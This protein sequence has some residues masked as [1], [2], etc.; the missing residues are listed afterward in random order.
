MIASASTGSVITS[1]TRGT[2]IAPMKT[3]AST[4]S[5]FRYLCINI[6]VSLHMIIQQK[7]G[8]A[9]L[10]WFHTWFQHSSSRWSALL[11]TDGVAV[12]RIRPRSR[13]LVTPGGVLRR[14]GL[15]MDG[16]RMD[17]ID[18]WSTA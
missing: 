6:K 2:V 14:S 8:E 3:S 15:R 13:W 10:T 9:C 5:S 4:A 1:V 12:D 11:L 16:L 18:G 7:A 17:G